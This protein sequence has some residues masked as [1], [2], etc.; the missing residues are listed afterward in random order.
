M[1]GTELRLHLS[2]PAPGRGDGAGW[3]SCAAAASASRG[4]A[5]GDVLALPGGATAVLLAPLSGRRGS[6]SPALRLPAPVPHYLAPPRRSRSATA[7]RA[8]TWP[9]ERYQTVYA[10][11]PG[12]AE[13]P[14]AGRPF[15]PELVTQL[16]A[17]GIDVAPLVLHTGVSSLE[18]GERPHA[19]WYR[20]P[21]LHGRAG[22][23]WRASWAAG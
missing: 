6:G 12:S 23:R 9:L 13:M 16:V 11:E 22:Q 17:A 14:S 10:N 19:E 15:T 5:E 1:R 7:T 3:S 20:V 8:E 2:S 4:G 21:R 18:A